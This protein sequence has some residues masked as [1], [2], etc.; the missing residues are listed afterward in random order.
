MAEVSAVA[1][2]EEYSQD[3]SSRLERPCLTVLPYPF[4]LL[5]NLLFYF[6]EN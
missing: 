4:P 5:E 6:S 1:R 2:P 3:G